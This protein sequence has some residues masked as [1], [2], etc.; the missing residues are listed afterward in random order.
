MGFCIPKNMANFE[1]FHQINASSI[2]LLFLKSDVLHTLFSALFFHCSQL[3]FFAFL[4]FF[5]LVDQLFFLF[6]SKFDQISI[7]K[8]L[9]RYY[10]FEGSTIL[11][12]AQNSE[13]FTRLFYSQ[14]KI[15]PPDRNNEKMHHFSIQSYMKCP[16]SIYII[17]KYVY[18]VQMP[19]Y[20]YYITY[21]LKQA[22]ITIS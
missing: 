1:S 9:C 20:I 4:M 21:Y 2:N 12:F 22:F 18:K 14:I 7:D 16:K 19:M 11:T 15:W 17:H 10:K 3:R 13:F 8:V 6:S 5:L